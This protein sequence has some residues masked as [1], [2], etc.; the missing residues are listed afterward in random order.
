MRTYEEVIHSLH[1]AAAKHGMQ[2]FDRQSWIDYV[3]LD[4]SY[5]IMAVTKGDEPPHRVRAEL[6]FPWPAKYTVESTHG[7]NCCM[8]HAPEDRCPH[9]ELSPEAVVALDIRYLLDVQ[10]AAAATELGDSVRALLERTL[11]YDSAPEIHFAIAEGGTGPVAV[12]ELSATTIWDIDVSEEI[13][14]GP[15]IEEVANVLTALL[16]SELL[17]KETGKGEG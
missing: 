4:R 5:R 9:Q 10:D 11:E 16:A 7:P 12:T 3:T 14:F 15:P 17:P 2:M 6:S 13:D 1:A 8:Y